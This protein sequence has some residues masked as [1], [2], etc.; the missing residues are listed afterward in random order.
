MPH[1]PYH[2]TSPDSDPTFLPLPLSNP[3]LSPLPYPRPPSALSVSW[4]CP[5]PVLFAIEPFAPPLLCEPLGC[6]SS[7]FGFRAFYR[8]PQADVPPGPELKPNYKPTLSLRRSP[9]RSL[10]RNKGNLPKPP[11]QSALLSWPALI[12]PPPCPPRH[13]GHTRNTMVMEYKR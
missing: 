3:Q 9:I 6:R 5:A 8:A 10:I 11:L 7:T 12:P 1:T 13:A 4:S 2:T